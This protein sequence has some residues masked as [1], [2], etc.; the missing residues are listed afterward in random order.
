[1]G[2]GPAPKSAPLQ[3]TDSLIGILK[4]TIVDA[5]FPPEP[6]VENP[7]V[8][9][10]ISNQQFA[11]NPLPPQTLEHKVNESYNF[12]INSFYK[13]MGRTIELAVF[14][15]EKIVAYGAVD[16]N[17]MIAKKA[18]TYEFRCI[19]HADKQKQFGFI[20]LKAHFEELP[21]TS[22]TFRFEAATV[23]RKLGGSSLA[24]KVTIGE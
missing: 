22:V 3:F 11:T 19:L 21:A 17:P 1:M 10:R 13:S 24:V 2:C 4:V 23:R 6:V 5:V 12:A 20:T 15:G 16:A 7:I 9:I 18:E 14:E 8:K